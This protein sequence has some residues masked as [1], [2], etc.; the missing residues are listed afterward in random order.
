[1]IGRTEREQRAIALEEQARRYIDVRDW[2]AAIERGDNFVVFDSREELFLFCHV[3]TKAEFAKAW[4]GLPTRE[5]DAEIELTER[6]YRAGYRV[7]EVYSVLHLNGVIMDCHIAMALV[8]LTDE[9]FQQMRDIGWD[10][11]GYSKGQHPSK[12]ETIVTLRP[13]IRPTMATILKI[14]DAIMELAK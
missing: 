7:C 5:R 9:E 10:P 14:K 2:Q 3:Q 8:Q 13:V 12:R 1:M 11:Q 4:D 6:I